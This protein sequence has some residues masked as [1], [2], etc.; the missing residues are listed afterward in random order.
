MFNAHADISLCL[1]RAAVDWRIKY[2]CRKVGLVHIEGGVILRACLSVNISMCLMADLRFGLRITFVAQVN[3]LAK[4]FLPH[5][6]GI[7]LSIKWSKCTS[8]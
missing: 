7:S 1:G 5:K 2:I 6:T 4:K 8:I 3:D